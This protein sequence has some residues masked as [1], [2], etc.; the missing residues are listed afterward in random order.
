MDDR[1]YRSLAE[2]LNSFLWGGELVG[3]ENLPERG[4]AVFV[5]NHVGA[6]GPIAVVASLPVRVYP[7]IIG[8]MIDPPKASAYLNMDFVEKQ[9]HLRPPLSLWLSA[10]LS[11][12]T[13]PLL[14]AVGCIGVWQ[15]GA[16]LE[17]YRISAGLLAEGKNLLIF[18]ED[19][20]QTLDQRYQMSPFQKGFA[21]LGEFFYQ[22]THQCLRFYPLV[23]HVDSLRVKVGKPIIFN[24]ANSPH[25]ERARIR[26]VLEALI[27][28]MYISM[29]ME[30]YQ[31]IPLPH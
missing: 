14:R 3:R 5:A 19:P 2:T 11:K 24:P 30:G 8:D 13:V 18:P 20:N 26:N 23:V 6:M 27:H 25:Q 1:I 7:W 4:P 9:L 10:V 16:L 21:H 31:G 12:I 22:R 29:T 28:E 17:T 15:G